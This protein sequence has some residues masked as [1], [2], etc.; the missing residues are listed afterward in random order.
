MLKIYKKIN[1]CWILTSVRS[2]SWLLCD[3]LNRTNLFPIAFEEYMHWHH[4]KRNEYPIVCKVIRRHFLSCHK[5]NDSIEKKLPKIKYIWLHRK[6]N[7]ERAISLYFSIISNVWRTNSKDKKNE[8]LR[9]Q[10]HIE[11]N[12][13]LA[14]ACY[15]EVCSDYH[16]KWDDFL[17]NRPHLHVDYDTFISDIENQFEL[18]LNYLNL[19]IKD[20]IEIESLPMKRPE[21][22]EFINKLKEL[23]SQNQLPTVDF[24]IS[25][26]IYKEL[27]KLIKI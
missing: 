9:R 10:T 14:L 12:P 6:N 24:S 7:Y 20:K 4:P 15:A 18:I 26:N 22:E 19:K 25:V 16:N 11:F 2:G 13:K 1:Y 5:D 3:L 27:N 8:F 23:V 21:T 17:S